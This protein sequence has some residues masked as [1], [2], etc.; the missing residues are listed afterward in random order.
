MKDANIESDNISKRLLFFNAHGGKL[1]SAGLTHIIM[2]YADKV[3]EKHS[4]L[5]P[6]R[7]SPHSGTWSRFHRRQSR[8]IRS[9]A[10]RSIY[11]LRSRRDFS[12]DWHNARQTIRPCLPCTLNRFGVYS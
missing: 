3:K 9:A 4:A 10:P 8:C 2:I 7:L 6:K 11:R 12:A 5:I 1:T